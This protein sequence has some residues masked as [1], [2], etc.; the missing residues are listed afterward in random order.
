MTAQTPSANAEGK[1]LLRLWIAGD[2]KLSRLWDVLPEA[3]IVGGAVRDRIAGRAVSDIDLASPLKPETVSGRLAAAGIR[4]VPTGLDHG[5]VTAVLDGRHFEITTLRRDVETDG[6]HAVVA[7][8]EDWREDAARRDFTINA[9][10]ME[11]DGTIH[12]HFGGQADLAAGLVRF[13]GD[14]A[15][16]IR[17]DFLRILRFFRFYGRYAVSPPDADAIDAI[18]SLREGLRQLS[19]ERVWSEIKRILAAPDP[20]PAL[21]LMAETGVLPL[22]LPEAA[23]LAALERLQARGAPADPLLRV[24]ALIG[25]QIQPLARRLKLADAER[26]RLAAIA[27]APDLPADADAATLRRALAERPAAVL[28]DR[29]WLTADDGDRSALRQRLATTERPAFPLKGRDV[30]A[31]GAEAGPSVGAAL[32][33]VRRWWIERDCLPDEAACRAELARHLEHFPIHRERM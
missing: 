16:R 27:A 6:R 33:A 28:A 7:F 25:G 15:T 20:L 22:V 11:R 29:S 19:A 32:A 5:T 31:L 2:E 9:M 12:D 17:E 4:A 8:T 26:A 30:L 23:S 18:R 14:P 13:V 1:T 10:S 21:R 3:R 24:A